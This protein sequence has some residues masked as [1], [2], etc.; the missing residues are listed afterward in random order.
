MKGNGYGHIQTSF[1]SKE[2]HKSKTRIIWSTLQ[3]FKKAKGKSEL[4]KV[5]RRISSRVAY[6]YRTV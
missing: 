4:A 6:A 3:S 5:Q 2:V 1:D